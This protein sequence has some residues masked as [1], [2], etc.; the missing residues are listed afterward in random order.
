MKTEGGAGGKWKQG[1]LCAGTQ[2]P[3]IQ[4]TGVFVAPQVSGPA[5]G[6]EPQWQTGTDNSN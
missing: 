5:R 2:S 6:P 4:P 3:S 1:L